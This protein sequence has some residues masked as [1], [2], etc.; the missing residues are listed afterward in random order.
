MH[1]CEDCLKLTDMALV[2]AVQSSV[3]LGVE[4]HSQCER[5]RQVT[6]VVLRPARQTT[7]QSAVL[8]Y[9]NIQCLHSDDVAC[10]QRLKHRISGAGT[11][12]ACLCPMSV[13]VCLLLA[14]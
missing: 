6:D 1:K 14:L 5:V 7:V 3:D 13:V 10:S 11:V 2:T 4:K 8:L 9:R 12:H